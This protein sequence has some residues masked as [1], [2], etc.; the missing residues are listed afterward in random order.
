MKARRCYTDNGER[1]PFHRD[2]RSDRVRSPI[3]EPGPHRVTDDRS[4]AGRRSAGDIIARREKTACARLDAQHGE[5]RSRDS[6]HSDL[7]GRAGNFSNGCAFASD[8]ENALEEVSS[9]E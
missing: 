2:P 7:I 5:I 3:E 8:A 9:S 6:A 1:N 4:P